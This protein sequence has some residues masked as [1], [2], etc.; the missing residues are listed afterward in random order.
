[1]KSL[2]LQCFIVL[3]LF[4]ACNQKNAQQLQKNGKKANHLIHETSPYLLQHA[5]NPVDWHPWN[6]KSL[7][8]AKKENKLLLVSIGYSA[9]HWCHVME[10]ESFED[11]LVAAKT[12]QYFVPIKVDREERPDV[13]DIY[14]TACHLINKSGGWPLNAIALPD[15]RPI[16]AGTYYPKDQWVKILEHFIDLKENS[17]QELIDGAEKLTQGIQST[18][19]IL[20]I[21]ENSDFTKDVI[22]SFD[23]KLLDISDMD[24]GGRKGEPKFPMPSIY[25]YMMKSYAISQNEKLKDALEVTLD[26]MAKGG[27]YDQIGGG[28]ARYSVDKEWLVPHFEK[29]LYDNG[30]LISVY[31]K[32]YQLTKKPLYKHVIEQTLD[33]IDREMTNEKGLFYASFDADSE[34]EEGKFYVWKK[35]EL[36]ALLEDNF[37]FFA[38]YF[39]VLEEGN[40]EHTNILRVKNSISELA[41]QY[42]LSESEATS[43]IEALIQKVF[44][45]RTKRIHPGLDDKSITSWN[46]LMI[47]GYCDAYR[48]LGHDKYR[49]KAIE[50]IEQLL[51]LQLKKSGN[52]MRNY[53]KG[54]S[55]INGFLD[56]YAFTTKALLDC[57]EITFDYK[58]LLQARN[59]MDYTHRHFYDDSTGMYFY[60]SDEDPALIARKRELADNV[61]PGS[62]SAT[63][64]NYLRLGTL[65]NHADYLE[66][67]RQMILNM[68]ETLES[69][70]RIDFYSNW[71]AL[72]LDEVYPPFEVAIVG[73]EV[74]SKR[75]AL[76]PYFLPNAILLGG[77]TE[78]QLEL[79]KDKA[80]EGVTRIFVCQKK[81]CKF[82]TEDID[83][84][85]ELIKH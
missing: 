56:D 85:I 1:M 73:E 51:A 40:W 26:E 52:L 82:P 19:Q 27:L 43:K 79:L 11:S 75:K 16:W 70:D 6:E 59:L 77:E 2:I 42:D 47:S 4:S 20:K 24:L 13:D 30:Q 54:V 5:Y 67:A 35:E 64:R 65:L 18:D 68:K 23:K 12:N 53:K 15:G 63:A 61:I 80:L 72:Y 36:K 21:S 31:A 78:G 76:M 33:F 46:G 28:F 66:R 45:E 14:M 55:T 49:K 32:G 74:H 29:M 25:E 44:Q 62:N 9:C 41:K 71:S 39:E 50:S 17:Y 10:H 83:K 58:Y 60:T 48:A 7:E 37:D 81:V 3:V 34:G 22:R 84:A 57:Y 38:S 8:K 69:T